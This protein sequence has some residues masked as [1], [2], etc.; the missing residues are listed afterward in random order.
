[1]IGKYTGDGFDDQLGPG[2]DGGRLDRA[3]EGQN[4]ARVG[5][6]GERSRR[7]FTREQT[8]F[9]LAVVLTERH[10]QLTLQSVFRVGGRE[11]QEHGGDL[12]A[13]QGALQQRRAEFAFCRIFRVERGKP[14]SRWR[15][16]ELRPLS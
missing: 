2:A 3:S 11:H 15:L 10:G 5:E 1:M 9:Q 14:R 6:V 7:R 8:R 4:L 16:D 12:P 13:R